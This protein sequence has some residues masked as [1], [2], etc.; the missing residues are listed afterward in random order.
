MIPSS[1]LTLYRDSCHPNDENKQFQIERKMKI[2]ALML[3]STCK[4]SS[5]REGVGEHGKAGG[6]GTIDE[7][8]LVA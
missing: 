5:V 3:V 1:G 2:C 7:D 6:E 8:T 4:D